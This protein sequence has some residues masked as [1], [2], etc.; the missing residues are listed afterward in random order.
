MFNNRKLG[1]A[2]AST[3]T[4]GEG[5]EHIFYELSNAKATYGKRHHNNDEDDDDEDGGNPYPRKPK[6]T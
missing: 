6:A 4:F 5:E 2:G 3:V 1:Q